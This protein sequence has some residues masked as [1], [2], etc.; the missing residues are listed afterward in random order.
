MNRTHNWSHYLITSMLL[1]LKEVK[2]HHMARPKLSVLCRIPAASSL[3]WS[4]VLL[5]LYPEF[6]I[7][8]CSSPEPETNSGMLLHDHATLTGT[9]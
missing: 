5:H 8:F 7:R 4:S 2:M 1:H 3:D 9:A 6:L